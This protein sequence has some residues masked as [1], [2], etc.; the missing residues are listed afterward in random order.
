MCRRKGA[1]GFMGAIGK[2]DNGRTLKDCAE[3]DGVQTHYMV[4]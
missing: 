3:A 4:S 2:D 1:T